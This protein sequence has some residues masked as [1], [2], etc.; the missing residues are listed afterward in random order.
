[1]EWFAEDRK[2]KC[3]ADHNVRLFNV[4]RKL[5][6][7][8]Y[9]TVFNPGQIKNLSQCTEEFKGTQLDL[10]LYPKGQTPDARGGKKSC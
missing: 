6:Y 4:I 5:G 2:T 3:L 8:A 1:M 7:E 9:T 10:L